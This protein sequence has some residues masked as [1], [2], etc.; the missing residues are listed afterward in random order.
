MASKNY[1]AAKKTL[2]Y[3]PK[4]YDS[5]NKAWIRKSRRNLNNKPSYLE[6]H[7]IYNEIISISK[8]T[9]TGFVSITVEHISPIF[10]KDLLT[11][12]IKEANTLKRQKDIDASNKALS[13]LKEELS[14][15][16]LKE[17]KESINQLIEA[18]LET[19][20]M[21]RLNEEY[22][23]VTL[24]PPFIPEEKSKPNRIYIFIFYTIFGTFLSVIGVLFRH[25]LLNKEETII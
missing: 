10:A 13:Y 23:L 7:E 17:I 1:D 15:T 19:Q 11:L 22:I 18:Q 6:A 25:Y 4:L 12:I 9:E 2:T 5:D 24:E 8:N 14:N 21:A 20:M 3:D 16:S